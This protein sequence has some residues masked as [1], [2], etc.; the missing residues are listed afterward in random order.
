MITGCDTQLFDTTAGVLQGDTLAPFL[1]IICLD[2][3]LRKSLDLNYDLSF[4]LVKKKS[5]RHQD[6]TITAID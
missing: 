6:I 1:F 2:Y 5:S 4:T 3:I